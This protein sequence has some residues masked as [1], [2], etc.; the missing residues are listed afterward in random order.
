M[1]TF[2]RDAELAMVEIQA[3]LREVPSVDD[4]HAMLLAICARFRPSALW[5]ELRDIDVAADVRAVSRWL[6]DALSRWPETSAML[7]W[8]N[9]NG[10]QDGAGW[11]MIVHGAD[12][13]KPTD[14][15]ITRGWET[16]WEGDE[17]L[18]VGLAR[19]YDVSRQPAWELLWAAVENLGLPAYA[20]LIVAEAL[21]GLR[22]TTPLYVQLTDGG[23][24]WAIGK[25]D[26]EYFRPIFLSVVAWRAS[27]EDETVDDDGPES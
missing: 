4:G 3:M 11:N 2:H 9:T 18:V 25:H 14:L 22:P 1:D 24:E 19:M 16:D 7:I 15:D 13:W 26:G 20:A 6:Q 23:D 10:M 27:L 21:R 8:L 12:G 17:H 5:D